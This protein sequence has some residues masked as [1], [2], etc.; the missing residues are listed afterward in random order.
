MPEIRT[1]NLERLELACQVEI[2]E[3]VRRRLSMEFGKLGWQG[4]ATS[5]VVRDQLD[6]TVGSLFRQMRAYVL[7]VPH[8]QESVVRVPA[9]W[10][11]A[12]KQRWAPPWWLRRHPIVEETICTHSTIW[13]AVCPHLPIPETG[14]DQHVYWL[15]DM[16]NLPVRDAD[17]A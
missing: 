8:R 15:A 11:Q 6:H 10:W 5:V 17:D 4:V 16:S 12:F 7:G 3:E 13:R 9:D 14:K 1:I 2:T